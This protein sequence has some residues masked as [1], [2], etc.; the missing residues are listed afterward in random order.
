MKHSLSSRRNLGNLFTASDTSRREFLKTGMSL[1]AVIS[2]L[3]MITGC[4]TTETPAVVKSEPINYPPLPYNKIQPP[5]E[6]CFVGFY[7]DSGLEKDSLYESKQR[8]ISQKA[9]NLDEY[10]DI[11]KNEKDLWSL[12]NKYSVGDLITFYENSTGVKP[13][14][15]SFHFPM[16]LG[17]PMERSVTIAKRGIVPYVSADIGMHTKVFSNG[18]RLSD[19]LGGKRDN[20]IKEYAQGALMFGKEH[21]GFFFTAM[22]ESNA[23]WFYWGQSSNLIPAWRHIW[24]IFEDEGAN[25]FATWVWEAYNPYGQPRSVM[26][27]PEKHYFGDKYVDWIGLNVYSN[28]TNPYVNYNK[29]FDELT[30]DI[31]RQMLNNHPRKPLML[32]AFGRAIG[33]DQPRWLV[34]A[35]KSIK[36]AFPEIRAAIHYELNQKRFDPLWTDSTLTTESLQRLKEILRDPYWIM[37]KE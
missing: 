14:I 8:E 37:A 26:D 2:G 33:N 3:E 19:I 29:M 32:S 17:F 36:N 12:I 18:F 16:Y 5:K 24:Q 21:G 15:L 9:K 1:V 10:V 35:Y 27:H 23:N 13:S 22:I 4:V 31:Y 30:R 28:D 25:Q 6:G 20:Y 34:N 7:K 11:L